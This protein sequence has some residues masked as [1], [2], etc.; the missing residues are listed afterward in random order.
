MALVGLQ[1]AFAQ[2]TDDN[3]RVARLRILGIP[4]TETA[5][6]LGLPEDG[7]EQRWKQVRRS[8]GTA[9]FGSRNDATCW[10]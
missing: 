5:D 9:I 10:R 8:L 2:L 4:Y 6:E 7:V 1:T 3:F